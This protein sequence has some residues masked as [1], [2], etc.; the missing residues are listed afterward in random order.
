MILSY[1]LVL[2]AILRRCVD[3]IQNSIVETNL[4]PKLP[5]ERSERD[6][7]IQTLAV[8]KSL[9]AEHERAVQRVIQEGEAT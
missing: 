4:E 1:R 5:S 7:Q 8:V 9:V 3:E 2:V 6:V